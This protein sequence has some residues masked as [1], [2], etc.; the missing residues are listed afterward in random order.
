MSLPRAPFKGPAELLTSLPEPWLTL[1]LL[2]AGAALGL[3]VGLFAL[4][5]ELTV[6]VCDQRVLL[7]RSGEPNTVPRA[8]LAQAFRDANDLVLLGPDSSELA[9]EPCDFTERRPAAAFTR[10]GHRWAD[11]DPYAA[12]FRLWVPG[13]PDLPTGADAL[14]KARAKALTRP[15][16]TTAGDRRELR[17][18]LARLGVYVRDEKKRQYW[19]SRT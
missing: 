12:E 8:E 4:H 10:H 3:L 5:E 7:I 13:A 15:D 19:R 1:G 2:V 14:L 9:R 17:A 16:S 18:E 11:T 6:R